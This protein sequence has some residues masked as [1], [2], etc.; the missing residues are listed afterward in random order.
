V[1]SLRPIRDAQ[2]FKSPPIIGSPAFRFPPSLLWRSLDRKAEHELKPVPLPPLALRSGRGWRLPSPLIL[3][4]ALRSSPSTFSFDCTFRLLLPA[5][6]KERVLSFRFNFN[7]SLF[8]VYLGSEMRLTISLP[9]LMVSPD[10]LTCL[11]FVVHQRN[12]P[13]GQW[14]PGARQPFSPLHGLFLITLFLDRE[15]LGFV[16]LLMRVKE[17]RQQYAFLV[18]LPALLFSLF[19]PLEE[20][21]SFRRLL[22]LILFFGCCL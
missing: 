17:N 10:T 13:F 6:E 18:P 14:V 21:L 5:F 8:V 15:I 20:T 22:L 7:Q 1:A 2:I 11:S 3:A 12:R 4:R 9:P 16:F 19:P